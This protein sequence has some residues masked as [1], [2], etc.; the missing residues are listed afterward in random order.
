MNRKRGA[1]RRGPARRACVAA[2]LSNEAWRLRAVAVMRAF[3]PWLYPAY[4]GE[5][6]SELAVGVRVSTPARGGHQS[7][8]KALDRFGIPPAGCHR[9]ALLGDSLRRREQRRRDGFGPQRVQLARRD[10]SARTGLQGGNERLNRIGVRRCAVH[11]NDISSCALPAQG[12]NRKKIQKTS[13]TCELLGGK[14]VGFAGSWD[15]RV[16]CPLIATDL[17]AAN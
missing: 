11:A 12:R 16:I 7:V 5:S 17:R 15:R 2:T 14:L 6:S 3:P 9:R 1:L 4:S 8:A 10:L 13:Q